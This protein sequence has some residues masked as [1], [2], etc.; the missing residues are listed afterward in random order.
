MGAPSTAII[1]NKAGLK[2]QNLA[3]SWKDSPAVQSLLD[4]ISVILAAEYVQVAKQNPETFKSS[5]V[6]K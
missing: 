5:V 4:T 6:S 2:T 1:E 3:F